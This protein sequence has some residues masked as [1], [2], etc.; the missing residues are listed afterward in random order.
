MKIIPSL[1]SAPCCSALLQSPGVDCENSHPWYPSGLAN[2]A[3]SA[4][5]RWGQ[6]AGNGDKWLDIGH[7]YITLGMRKRCPTIWRVRLEQPSHRS[8][9]NLKKENQTEEKKK[10]EKDETAELRRCPRTSLQAALSPNGS[11]AMLG[12]AGSVPTQSVAGSQGLARKWAMVSVVSSPQLE[13]WNLVWFSFGVFSR[14][15]LEEN[16]KGFY[17]AAAGFPKSPQEKQF[18]SLWKSGHT[19]EYQNRALQV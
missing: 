7:E 18:P 11:W 10:R 13:R 6:M 2:A 1:P 15:S 14:H 12:G 4:A 8:E 17:V 16:W 19:F 5:S 9:W 3:C